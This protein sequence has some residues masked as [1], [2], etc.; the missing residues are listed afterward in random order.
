MT[1]ALERCLHPHPDEGLERHCLL[2]E[3]PINHLLRRLG[4]TSKS[5]LQ[6]GADNLPP[7]KMSF[8][9]QVV[10]KVSDMVLDKGMVHSVPNLANIISSCGSQ[11]R[12]VESL[13]FKSR[14][15]EF[16][17]G[18]VTYGEPFHCLGSFADT[19]N[20]VLRMELK[21]DSVLCQWT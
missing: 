18:Q 5:T 1:Y 17:T 6:L 12:E 7:I 14:S 15:V 2:H 21:P 13:R 10:Q 4:I 8:K 11:M 16:D 20:R 19:D 9:P 3:I